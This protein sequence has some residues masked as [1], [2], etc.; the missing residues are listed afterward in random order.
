MTYDN[1]HVKAIT[2]AT[3]LLSLIENLEPIQD[4]DK[5]KEGLSQLCFIAEELRSKITQH[6]M[7]WT[8]EA[9]KLGECPADLWIYSQ[10]RG[11]STWM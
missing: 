1:D 10:E 6:V 2:K 8:E 5:E 3:Q 4:N 7:K 11:W 9:I